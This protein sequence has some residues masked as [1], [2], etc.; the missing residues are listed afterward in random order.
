MRILLIEDDKKIAA[1]V[2]KGL[3]DEGYAVDVASDGLIGEEFAQTNNYDAIILDIMLPK[4]DGWQTC[5]QIRAAG[6]LT[7]ILM[8]TALDD[9]NDKIRGLDEGAD[10]YLVKP[11]HF[12]ELLARLRSLIRRGTDVRSTRVEKFGV[13]L[14]VATHK[15]YRDGHEIAL[16]A[17]EFALLELFM[18]HA[19]K[20]LSRQAISE[21][22]WD[23]NFDPRSNVIEA[24]VKFL[25]QKIDKCFDKPLI[26]TVRGAGYLFSDEGF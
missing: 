19:G 1:A 3:R 9:V 26:H 16:S 18:M 17:K 7:P 8:L 4:Q 10:D 24:F 25:R 20:I 5:A 14:D 12:G 15:A 13:I 21:H 2:S 11:F 22:L 23:I 6:V